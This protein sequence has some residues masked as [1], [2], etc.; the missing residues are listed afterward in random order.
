ML[1]YICNLAL[2]TFDEL[3]NHLM[4]LMRHR[5]LGELLLP[6]RCAQKGCGSTFNKFYN[7]LRHLKTFHMS[8]N[9]AECNLCNAGGT[10]LDTDM[11][12]ADVN[13]CS[14]NEPLFSNELRR[15]LQDIHAD[16]EVMVASLRANSAVPYCII[17]TVVDH[18]NHIVDTA[19]GAVANATVSGLHSAGVH[20]DVIKTVKEVITSQASLLL[21]PLDFLST[22]YKQDK[23]FDLHPLAVK[24]QTIVLGSRVD[25]HRGCS[26]VVHDTFQ[27]VS[28]EP[29]LRSLLHNKSYVEALLSDKCTPGILTEWQ[30]G[31][32]FAT[33]GIFSDPTRLTIVLQLFYD[34]MGTTNPLRGQS[35]MYNVGVFYFTVKNLPNTYNSCF[36]N[37]HLLALC[38]TNELKKYGFESVLR[39]IVDELTHLSTVGFCGEFP[40]IGSKQIFVCLGQVACDN[41]ALNS[42]LGF[43]ECFSADY[44]CTMCYAKQA[45]TQSKYYEHEFVR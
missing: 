11:H 28:V 29:T 22:R 42:I 6:Y 40:I 24:P 36:A 43:I 27:Y 4:N 39:K 3:R 38:N 37:V 32:H 20:S 13:C 23:Y 9:G 10:E 25:T 2:P 33:S 30:D 17:P 35:V 5:V 21:Q 14:T 41:L 31:A 44:F 45:D 12:D 15:S 16:G 7:L 18:C 19:V 1:C 8:A 26:N 34:G